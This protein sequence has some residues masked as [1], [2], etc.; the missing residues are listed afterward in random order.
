MNRVLIV[1]NKWWECDPALAAMLNSN[2]GGCAPDTPW[3]TMLHPTRQ[4]PETASL[5]NRNPSPRA[6]FRY[7]NFM[8]ELWCISDL[9][10][11]LPI[12]EQSSSQAKVDRLP[13]IFSSGPKPMLVIAVGTAASAIDDYELI[14]GVAIGTGVFMNDGL[15][16]DPTSPSNWQGAF[17]TLIPSAVT[18][19]TFAA[20]S[21]MD[22]A[23]ALKA[24]LPMPFRNP[25]PTQP[26]ALPSISIGFG[27]VALGTINVTN[28]LAY[29]AADE[30]TIDAFREAATGATPVS[31]ETTHGLVR[32]QSD[33]PFIFVSGIVNR[34]LHF[35][36]DAGPHQT[37][38]DLAGAHNAGVTVS[39][40]LSSLNK[41]M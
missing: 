23:S 37:A 15:A 21:N 38:Q 3:P 16:S 30:A 41:R 11:G 18:Q 5:F 6:I 19:Q 31:L 20:I 2:G 36:D 4:V 28:Y 9:L 39:W 7:A 13:Q 32:V 27:D 12:A 10:D 8:A 35:N 25:D 14:G 26:M 22:R 24:F 1:V 40:L 17:D 34:C 29:N 33:S